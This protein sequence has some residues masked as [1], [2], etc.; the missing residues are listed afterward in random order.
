MFDQFSYYIG[1]DTS[2]GLADTRF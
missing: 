1:S 2:E